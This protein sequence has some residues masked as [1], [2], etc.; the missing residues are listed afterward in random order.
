MQLNISFF[1]VFVGRV[2][3]IRSQKKN[4]Q[5]VYNGYIYNKKQTQANGHTT[6]RC[7]DVSKNRCRAVCI[8]KNS[9]L[10]CARRAHHHD[11]HWTRIGNRQL[12]TVEDDLDRINENHQNN[13]NDER[14]DENK[15]YKTDSNDRS[16]LN[17]K[18]IIEEV[19][20]SLD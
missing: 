1:I 7:S 11:G 16:L 9:A 18:M 5:L 10:V 15:I 8:T 19:R 13:Q 2:L 20:D 4:P 14:T 6:W 3:Y 12:Y 17:Y